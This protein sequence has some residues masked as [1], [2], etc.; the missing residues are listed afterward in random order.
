M[1]AGT[2]LVVPGDT[3]ALIRYSTADRSSKNHPIY[4]FNYYH[5][6]YAASGGITADT[7]Y[8]AQKTLMAT[9]ASSWV[10]GFSDGSITVT[11][12]GPD[13]HAA[14]GSL[15]EALLTHRDLPR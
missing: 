10:T 5:G 9:Y 12:S 14:T 7:P 4:L 13:G 6:V 2:G 3:A 8:A 11:R 1:A 15:V